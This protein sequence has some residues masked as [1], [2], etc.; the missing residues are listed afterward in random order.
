ML[1]AEMTPGRWAPG[2]AA[3]P[4]GKVLI[5]GG[6]TYNGI[7]LPEMRGYLKSAEIFDPTTESFS[8]AAAEMTEARSHPAVVALPNGK[9]LIAGAGQDTFSRTAELFNPTTETFEAVSNKMVVE[10]HGGQVAALLPSG[11]VLIA[12]GHGGSVGEFLKTAEVFNPTTETFEALSAGMAEARDWATAA[13]LRD[14]KVLIAGGRNGNLEHCFEGCPLR[15]A[16]VFNPTTETF[17][18]LSAEMIEPRDWGPV[19]APLADGDVLIVGGRSEFGFKGGVEIGYLSTA[20][21]YDPAT[22]SFGKLAVETAEA[23][24]FGAAA[25]LAD[26]KVLIAGGG[27]A[28][29]PGLGSAEEASVLTPL[30]QIAGGAFGDQ[31]VA[32][33]SALQTLEVRSAGIDPLSIHG[34]T[35]S[36]GGA[37]DFRIEQDDCA[38]VELAFGQ[39]CPIEVSFVPLS[40]G[41]FSATLRLADN[42]REPT[43]VTLSGTGVPANSGPTGVTGVNG[44]P[45]LA[46]PAGATGIAGTTGVAGGTGRVGPTGQEGPAGKI[47]LVKCMAVTKM[48]RGKRKTSQKCTTSLVSGPVSFATSS[49]TAKA[50]LSRKGRVVAT[51]TLR[52]IGGRAEFV[53]S[54][55]RVLPPGRYTL[56]VRRKTGRHTIARRQTITIV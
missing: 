19:A 20:E 53:S 39:T 43:G 49:A 18:G 51:G 27:N 50:T 32:K 13:A 40:S 16:E 15:S 10:R 45:G 17:E 8:A 52:T 56:T 7:G 28:I 6:Y 23:R 46:G 4:D 33:P 22:E 48:V 11:K 14:G 9:V 3:L 30:A 1:S 38:G 2:A 44:T 47:E 35:V 12:G 54:S 29:N 31:T 34:A 24:A 55:A 36:G 21:F 42:E 25:P 37:T 41:S 26:G 5:V